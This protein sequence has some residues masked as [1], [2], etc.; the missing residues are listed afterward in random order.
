MVFILINQFVV[1]HLYKFA[2][3]QQS[4]LMTNDRILLSIVLCIFMQ[5]SAW[6]QISSK[7]EIDS[8]FKKAIPPLRG[9]GQILP[10]LKLSQEAL[11]K[12]ISIDYQE[13]TITGYI[14]TAKFLSALGRY[15]EGLQ[16]LDLANPIITK[17]GNYFYIT[18]MYSEYGRNYAGI[19][20]RENALKYYKQAH[21][22][23]K[24]ITD[25]AKKKILL[26]YL[27][28]MESGLY[29]N[30]SDTL[31]FA[32]TIKHAYRINPSPFG[33]AR[34]IKY[35]TTYDVNLDS[36]AFYVQQGDS[37]YIHGKFEEHQNAILLR[38]KGRYYLS[39]NN[40]ELA[41]KCLTESAE[42][43]K[44]GG[45]YQDVRD[46]FK[47]LYEAYDKLND[48]DNTRKFLLAYTHLNDSI[49]KSLVKSL[50]V[51]VK[52]LIQERES[53]NLKERQKLYILIGIILFA[54]LV[55]GI[56]THK[57]RRE[58]KEH[59]DLLIKKE[60][61][62]QE[63]QLKVNNAFDELLELAKA[64]NPHFYVRF[65]EVYPS[66]QDKLLKIAPDLQ[67]S[68]LQLCA[69][70][71]LDFTTKE[72]AESTFRSTRTIENRKYSLRKKLGVPH[73]A[74]MAVWMKSL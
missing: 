34:L 57:I 10:A 42:I 50:D 44:K 12:S 58:R 17:R 60:T 24:Y 29:E 48:S 15:Q 4:S 53:D 41:I 46:T 71:Y 13:G 8:I 56:Y 11:A 1:F 73:T 51:P 6:S 25:D 30:T 18:Q 72:I 3:A 62:S 38:N 52:N 55:I 22:S 21:H 14:T 67:S 35:F 2:P 64:N 27:L 5:V 74:F 19:G 37:L 23:I 59:Q 36:A 40:I 54:V 61:E 16:Q 31:N 7:T 20:L 70:L 68:E 49:N 28:L 33:A 43:S 32:R 45:K 39:R 26:D 47:L 69:Y 9:K 66:L 63:L 65:Q